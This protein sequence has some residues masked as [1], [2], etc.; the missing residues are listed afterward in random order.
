MQSLELSVFHPWK[1]VVK[2]FDEQTTITEA[3][4]DIFQRN[5]ISN[6]YKRM[7]T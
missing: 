2:R 1:D 7:Y 3:N 6:V 5:N 4:I